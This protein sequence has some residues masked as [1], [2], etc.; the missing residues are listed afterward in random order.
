MLRHAN[1]NPNQYRED[2]LGLVQANAAE[3]CHI[4]NLYMSE[5]EKSINPNQKMQPNPVDETEIY[6]GLDRR[7]SFMWC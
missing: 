2:E 4:C 5:S 3:Y 1:G 6:R 7:E